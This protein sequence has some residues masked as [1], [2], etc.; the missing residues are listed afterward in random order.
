KLAD[1]LILDKNPLEN[2]RHTNSVYRVMKNGRLYDGNTANEVYPA[3]RMLDRRDINYP[4]PASN[5]GV[6]E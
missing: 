1:L 3:S 4:K 6:K 2:I 5:T